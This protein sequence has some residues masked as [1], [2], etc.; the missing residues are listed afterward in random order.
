MKIGAPRIR[1]MRIQGRKAPPSGEAALATK[2][3]RV[4]ALE[5]TRTGETDRFRYVSHFND[6]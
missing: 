5:N 1:E 6:L 4:E 3:N 2:R